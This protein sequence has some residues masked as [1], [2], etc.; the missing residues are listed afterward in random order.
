MC[1][2]RIFDAQ[3]HALIILASVLYFLPTHTDSD[4]IRQFVTDHKIAAQLQLLSVGTSFQGAKFD[5]DLPQT[6]RLEFAK[7]NTKVSKPKLTSPP[8]G[9]LPT[10]T[11]T[12]FIHPLTGRKWNK[13]SQHHFYIQL[14]TGQLALLAVLF[15]IT[16]RVMFLCSFLEE[17][18]ASH[19]PFFSTGGAELIP[20]SALHAYSAEFANSQAA[21][22]AHQALLQH[23]LA[24]ATQ[25]HLP[26]VSGGYVV[27][28]KALH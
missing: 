2:F 13:T 14:T 15:N 3:R 11:T 28:S 21:L 6:I 27:R 26:A 22:P 8:A 20:A 4:T 7:S 18:I 23:Q 10:S 12:T 24:A 9:T 1:Q 19:H 5:P 16:D 25:H 17:I